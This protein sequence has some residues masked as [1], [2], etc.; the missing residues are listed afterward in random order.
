M[1]DFVDEVEIRVEAGRGGDGCVAFRREKYVPRGGPAG[2]DGGDGGDV[3]ILADGRLRTLLDLRPRRRVRAG[4]G[5]PGRGKQQ[6]G[7]RGRDQEIRVP[8]GTV[9]TD[10]DSGR[11]IADLTGPGQRVVAARGGAGGRGNLRFASATNRAPR[12]AEEGRPGEALDLRLELKLMADVGLLGLPNVGKSTLM[13]KITKARP[14]VAPYPFTTLAPVLGVCEL[15][16]FQSLVVADIPGLVEGA[17][18]GSGLGHRFLRHL[19]RTA[20][21]VHL[22]DPTAG[23]DGDPVEIFDLLNQELAAYSEALAGLPQVVALNKIDLPAARESAM[24]LAK[25]FDARGI[26]LHRISAVTGEG[27]KELLGA[28]FETVAASGRTIDE[29]R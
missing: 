23:R 13:R 16:A 20:V 1:R 22:L 19:E 24:D 4:S 12:E 7:R 10:S 5:E 28:L 29:D 18:T 21:L 15:G 8:R 14:K 9:V 6:N 2:G 25:A 26:R 3:V 27:V 17:S 11:L